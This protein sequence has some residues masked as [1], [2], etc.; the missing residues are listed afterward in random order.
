MAGRPFTKTEQVI[1]TVNERTRDRLDAL[2][3]EQE[4]SR[5]EVIR[6]AILRHLDYSDAESGAFDGHVPL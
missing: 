5:A 6:D 2:A 1:T 4:K 3:D